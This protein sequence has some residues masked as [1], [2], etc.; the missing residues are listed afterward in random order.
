MTDIRAQVVLQGGTNIPEDRFIN[1][2]HFNAPGSLS[3]EAPGIADALA[4]FYG[5]TGTPG[6]GNGAGI[7]L[8]QF[9]LRPFTIRLYDL[10]DPEPR[11]PIVRSYTLPTY[12]SSTNGDLPEEVAIVLS[13]RGA[14]PV[15]RSRRGRVYIGPL[16][17][18]VRDDATTAVPT[19]PSGAVQTSLATYAGA[20][21]TARPDWCIWS[22]TTSIMVPVVGGHI[23]NAFDTQRRRGPVTT[24]RTL[25]PLP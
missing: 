20:L 16:N 10:A 5:A 21:L 13:L 11:V 25:W 14:P 8:S 23:D 12:P 18:N 6:A 15:T 7:Y 3:L 1:V 2:F 9:V 22:P 24:A 4:S 19:R 17:A